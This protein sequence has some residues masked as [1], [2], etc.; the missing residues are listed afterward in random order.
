M[1]TLKDLQPKLILM[2]G[3]PALYLKYGLN[4][5]TNYIYI[6]GEENI[7]TIDTDFGIIG[8]DYKYKTIDLITY[9]IKR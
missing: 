1:I 6:E 9:R 3:A 2:P 7:L 8:I 5:N 4:D